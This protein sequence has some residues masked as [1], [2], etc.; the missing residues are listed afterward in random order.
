[1]KVLDLFSGIGGFSLGLEWAGMSTVAMCE[2]DPY[3][4]K[5]LA[6]HWP[7]LTIHEDIRNLDGKQYADSI[8]VVCGDSP[9]SPSRLQESKED[10]TMTVTSGLKCL[11]SSKNPNHD[12]LLERMF[13]VH[14]YGT[15]QC[16]S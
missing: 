5:I 10:Q 15:R 1:M 7:H 3:C 4:R 16:A 8:D 6:K 13:W 12:G 2:K 11:E 9:V 14:Q